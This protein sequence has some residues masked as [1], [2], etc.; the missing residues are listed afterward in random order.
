MKHNYP[1]SLPD[2]ILMFSKFLP[3]NNVMRQMKET[4]TRTSIEKKK[5]Y[6]NF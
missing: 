6:K 5:N 1:V 2:D 4:E 3:V